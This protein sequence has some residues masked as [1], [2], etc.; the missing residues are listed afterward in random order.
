MKGVLLRGL[1]AGK[2]MGLNFEEEGRKDFVAVKDG[3][4]GAKSGGERKRV[5]ADMARVRG[6]AFGRRESVGKCEREMR[7]LIV[8]KPPYDPGRV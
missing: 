8:D 5:V 6:R 4:L 7:K 3:S 1:K 2:E